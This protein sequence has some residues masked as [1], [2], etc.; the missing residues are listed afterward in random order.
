ML[1]FLLLILYICSANSTVLAFLTRVGRPPVR[2]WD[3]IVVKCYLA[4]E[5]YTC[6][7]IDLLLL[8]KLLMSVM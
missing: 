3:T 6:A 2:T 4:Y 7:E 1:R 5:I 8:L